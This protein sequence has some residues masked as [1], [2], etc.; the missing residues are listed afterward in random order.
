MLS[1]GMR[2]KEVAPFYF[3]ANAPPLRRST[4]SIGRMRT[5]KLI[6]RV[7]IGLV[8]CISIS[9]LVATIKLTTVAMPQIWQ[10]GL[11]TVGATNHF[12]IG[13]IISMVGSAFVFAWFVRAAFNWG[14]GVMFVLFIATVAL[15]FLS[16][17]LLASNEE[18]FALRV[19]N[20]LLEQRRITGEFPDIDH[21]HSITVLGDTQTN[22]WGLSFRGRYVPWLEIRYSLELGWYYNQE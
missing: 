17:K 10:S 4:E 20:Q 14:K 3:S 19:G 16:A 13:A 2:R 11:P 9:L 1:P 15:L 6:R 12:I 8:G 21:F 7:A 22:N 18:K 5:T